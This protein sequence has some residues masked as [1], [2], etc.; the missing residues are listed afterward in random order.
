MSL[1]RA[2]RPDDMSHTVTTL[3]FEAQS[4]TVRVLGLQPHRPWRQRPFLLEAGDFI[5][6]SP[7]AGNIREAPLSPGLGNAGK[8]EGRTGPGPDPAGGW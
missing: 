5:M 6:H 8:A 2:A 1:L 3:F 7:V 4:C